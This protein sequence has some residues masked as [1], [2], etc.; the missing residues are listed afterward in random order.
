MA[1]NR[2][3]S[4]AGVR[5]FDCVSALI[6]GVVAA[7]IVLIAAVAIRLDS[8]GPVVY[9]QLR[10]GQEGRE[11][12]MLK[13]RTMRV[14]A[15]ADGVPR[16]AVSSDRRVTRVG[17]VLRRCRIDEL[18][19]LWNIVRGDMSLIGPRPERPPFVDTLSRE[20]PGYSLRHRVK[21]GLTGWAQVRCGY[22][23]CIDEAARK[24]EYDL[25]YVSHRNWR[26][27]LRILCATIGVLIYGSGAR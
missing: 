13:L 18:P 17:R 8:R 5:A 24:L 1:P 20:L 9:R 10:V 7:P 3:S 14:D 23:G 26:L 21:P 11:F 15:E 25:Y 19:Q 16:W 27:D 4:Q 12:W 22:A 6:L 2:Q